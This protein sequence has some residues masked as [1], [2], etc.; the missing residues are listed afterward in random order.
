M[1]IFSAFSPI[2]FE[3][4]YY[5]SNKC[6]IRLF[7][8]WPKRPVV[9]CFIFMSVF[10]ELV[11]R[12]GGIVRF[13]LQKWQIL[14]GIFFVHKSSRLFIRVSNLPVFEYRCCAITFLLEK[15]CIQVQFEITKIYMCCKRCRSTRNGTGHPLVKLHIFCMAKS[16]VF[17]CFFLREL[18]DEFKSTLYSTVL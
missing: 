2:P 9:N 5:I 15:V 12:G 3:N 6:V 10:L 4:V 17:P 1:R 8:Y 14:H 7:L 18:L 13:H 11:K 16:R